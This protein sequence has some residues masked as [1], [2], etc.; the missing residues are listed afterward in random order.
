MAERKKLDSDPAQPAAAAKKKAPDK[1][2]SKAAKAAPR[3]SAAPTRETGPRN[4]ALALKESAPKAVRKKAPPLDETT[5]LHLFLFHEGTDSRAYEFLGSRVVRRGR[6]SGVLFRVWA[7]DARSVSVMGDFCDWDRDAH[8]M[9]KISV[10]V[11][12]L[13]IPGLKEFDAYKYAI[14]SPQG[15]HL[16]KADPYAFH[17]ETRPRTAS[18]VYTLDGYEWQD[19]P[20]RAAQQGAYAKPLNIYEVHLGSWRRGEND[21]LLSYEELADQLIPYVKEMGYTHIELLPVTEHPLDASWGYQVTGYFAPTSRFGTPHEFMAFVDRCHTAGVGVLL[22]WVPAHFPKD[23]HGLVEFDGTYCY[24]YGD[25]CKMEHKEWGTRVFDYGRNETRSFLMSSA[26]FWFD[27]YHIDGLRVDAVASMLYLDYARKD[28]QW[29]PNVHGGREN[30]EA[31]SFLRQLNEQVFAAFPGALM[32]AEE[33]TAWPMVTKPPYMGGLGFN[34][35]WNMGWMNDALHYAKQDPI[36]R[37]FNHNDLTFSLVY[38]FSE[39]Y[40]LPVS[41]DEVVHGKCSLLQKMPGYY[42]DKFAGVR[43]FLAYMMGHP[44]KKLH[45]MGNEFGQFEEWNFARPLD[46]SL[47]DFDKHKQLQTYVKALNHLYLSCPAF[48]EC[49]CEWRGFDW[50]N[51]GDYQ[52]NTLAFRRIDVNGGEVVAIFNFSPMLKE[53]YRLGVPHPG[54]YRVVLNSDAAI[55]GGWNHFLPEEVSTWPEE[56]LDKPHSLSITLPP[57]GAVILERIP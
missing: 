29:R 12:E 57:Y 20:W 17:A 51:H 54:R 21:R 53:Y 15:W 46:W 3:T 50:V 30:L 18:K 47:L 39:N 23:P 10:G 28:G 56:W 22:D 8:P 49:D 38:A 48:W 24:E 45:F 42:D 34:F 33:S 11:W 13:F 36:F 37:Q 55:F 43:V 1:P 5:Q 41:H 44:G 40:I 31:I 16:E 19:D 6:K 52:G 4:E 14:V 2:V 27:K 26:L 32:M 25:P 9:E 7:P 35:K